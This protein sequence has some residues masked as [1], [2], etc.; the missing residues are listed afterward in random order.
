MG[1]FADLLRATNDDVWNPLVANPFVAAMADGSLPPDNFRFYIEQNIQYLPQYARTLAL[2]AARATTEAELQRFTRS[3]NQIVNVEM[4]ANRRLRDRI[5]ELGAVDHG[6]GDGMA[7][8]CQGYAG[9]LIATAAT[10]STVDIMAAMLPCAWSY[11]V[12]AAQYPNPTSHPV[13][14]DWI[15]FFGGDEYATYLNKLVDELDEV[16]CDVSEA[17]LTRLRGHFR[18][19]ARFERLFWEMGFTMERWPDQKAKS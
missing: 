6:G 9:Y 5:I 11:H 14:T 3:L 8:A 10:G 7:P 16:V 1:H 19:G 17:D 12:I 15:T 4:D 13:Y 2:G 18:T